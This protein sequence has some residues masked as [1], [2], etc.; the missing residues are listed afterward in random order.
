MLSL[1]VGV[2]PFCHTRFTG[3]SHRALTTPGLLF[4]SHLIV[5]TSLCLYL[6]QLCVCMP[7][8]RPHTRMAVVSGWSAYHCIAT[9]RGARSISLSSLSA[10]CWLQ[11]G[12]SV[13]GVSGLR[14]KLRAGPPLRDTGFQAPSPGSARTRSPAS[15]ASA[16]QIFA[17]FTSANIRWQSKHCSPNQSQEQERMHPPPV[18]KAQT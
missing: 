10:C 4:C 6:I 1:S 9:A 15:C 3:I 11:V 12:R 13:R 16:F 18:G 8:R 7:K 17:C 2:S 5:Y 14:S